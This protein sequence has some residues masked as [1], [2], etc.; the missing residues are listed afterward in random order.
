MYYLNLSVTIKI[1][2]R[3]TKFIPTL[4]TTPIIYARI[5]WKGHLESKNTLYNQQFRMSQKNI[6]CQ[7]L[8]VTMHIHFCVLLTLT[9]MAQ[10]LHNNFKC[11]FIISNFIKIIQMVHTGNSIFFISVHCNDGLMRFEI[12]YGKHIHI[13]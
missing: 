6:A 1:M 7:R 2:P 11:T 5:Y 4:N 10:N 8:F 9:D 12:K 13:T 3:G